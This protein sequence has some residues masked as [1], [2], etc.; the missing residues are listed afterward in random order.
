MTFLFL[1]TGSTRWW[2]SPRLGLTPS[3][4]L[5]PCL[6]SRLRRW[7]R[8]LLNHRRR[9]R[10]RL[11]FQIFQIFNMRTSPRYIQTKKKIALNKAGAGDFVSVALS[12]LHNVKD[13]KAAIWVEHLFTGR[14]FQISSLSPRTCQKYSFFLHSGNVCVDFAGCSDAL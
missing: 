3:L 6:R 9:R 12:F 8:R 4:E 14:I 10:E 1:G 5:C 13:V 7:R 11:A 2:T